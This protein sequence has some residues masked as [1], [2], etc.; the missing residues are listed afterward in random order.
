MGINGWSF[1]S[2]AA[3]RNA[4]TDRLI[5]RPARG[6]FQSFFPNS[7]FPE[8][9]TNLRRKFSL[10]GKCPGSPI[11]ERTDPSEEILYLHHFGTALRGGKGSCRADL[12][13]G[14]LRHSCHSAL[15]SRTWWNVFL[16]G[17]AKFPDIFR[18]PA[19]TYFPFSCKY[20]YRE[21]NASFGA[22][23][24]EMI[25]ESYRYRSP[26]RRLSYNRSK[27]RKP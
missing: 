22:E 24:G 1:P 3:R 7:G 19:H 6:I 15:L 26:G 14:R 10:P 4:Y 20:C 5:I 11:A 18:F 16:I 21:E 13:T 8:S 23:K 12:S 2:V 9:C 25:Y 27:V 17:N